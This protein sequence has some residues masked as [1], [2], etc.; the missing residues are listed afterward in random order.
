[1]IS[2]LASRTLPYDSKRST[3]ILGLF[4]HQPDAVCPPVRG[5]SMYCPRLGFRWAA[6]T[7]SKALLIWMLLTRRIT[8]EELEEAGKQLSAAEEASP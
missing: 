7:R 1:M 6:P 3:C 8:K 4:G 5:Q 2:S